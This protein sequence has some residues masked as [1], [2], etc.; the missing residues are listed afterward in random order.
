MKTAVLLASYNGEKYIAQQ[1][2]SILNQEFTDFNLFISDD[3]SSDRTVDII[4]SYREKYSDRIFILRRREK[5]EKSRTNSACANFLYLL[6]NTGSDLYFFCDQDDFW[7]KDHLSKLVEK[8]NS[9]SESEKALPVLIFTDL[10]VVDSEL[11]IINYSDFAYAKRPSNPKNNSYFFA[12]NIR[13]CACCINSSVKELVFRNTEKL[14]ENIDKVEMH[15]VFVTL[16]ASFFG[17]KYFINQ[18]TLL[19]RQHEN[20]TCGIGTKRT[21]AGMRKKG[22]SFSRYRE[23]YKKLKADFKQRQVYASFFLEYFKDILPEKNR[24]ELADFVNISKKLKLSK[25]LFLIKNGF[26]KYG[27]INNIW[28]FIVC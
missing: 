12:T 11:N 1:I 28:L 20:N 25:I 19:Y 27:I 9:L 8:Y 17:K 13:G 24:K 4:N 16:T 3:G 23:S 18:P 14:K 6:E 15:D 22:I 26:L 5:N 10:S 2:D 7:Q 21:L